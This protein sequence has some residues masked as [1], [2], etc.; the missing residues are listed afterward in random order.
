M[1][2]RILCAV[3]LA[4]LAALAV[5]TGRVR[6]LSK[7]LAAQELAQA[8]QVAAAMADHI[9]RADQAQKAA[10]AYAVR[11]RRAA[12]DAAGAR[13]ELDRLRDTL[14]AAGPSDAAAS[15]AGRADDAGRAR[16][17][18]GECAAALQTV[19]A[20]ADTC[21][22]RLTGLQDYVRAVLAPQP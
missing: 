15:A 2:A 10:D 21:E 19:A 22:S 18:V 20:A 11:A 6:S 7:Q 8:Q 3:L 17:V 12:S 1:L 5:Q 13:S 4:A 16:A 9:H 14:T